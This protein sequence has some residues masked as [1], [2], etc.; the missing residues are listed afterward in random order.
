[1]LFGII[2]T[3]LIGGG[4]N[5]PMGDQHVGFMDRTKRHLKKK[6]LDV[7]IALIEYSML[8]K[9]YAATPGYNG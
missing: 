5:L 2:L 4:F 9:P 1:M 7:D 3:R 8:L 6:G